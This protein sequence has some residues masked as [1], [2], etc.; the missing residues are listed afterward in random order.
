[1]I[2]R[3]FLA[4]FVIGAAALAAPMGAAAQKKGGD[5]VIGMVQAPPSWATAT[6]P[7][8]SGRNAAHAPESWTIS[9]RARSGSV[10]QP[11]ITWTKPAASG[12]P[13]GHT[14]E[15]TLARQRAGSGGRGVPPEGWEERAYPA[16]ASAV[17]GVVEV[18]AAAGLP[19]AR[20]LATC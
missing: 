6:L 20:W 8:I 7:K 2:R 14:E 1:M 5:I 11:C 18:E 9:S 13:P 16:S 10:P 12:S 4:A 19:S 15:A 17:V 3:K